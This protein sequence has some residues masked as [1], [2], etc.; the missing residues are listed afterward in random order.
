MSSRY[1]SS[2]YGGATVIG[3]DQESAP[4]LQ[5]TGALASVREG[6]NLLEGNIVAEFA[7]D[8]KFP[9]G[10]TYDLLQ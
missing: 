10:S 9:E 7:D 6:I 5:G 8:T 2:L 1:A 3:L 4:N